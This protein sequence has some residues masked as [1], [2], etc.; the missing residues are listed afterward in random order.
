MFIGQYH[1]RL[2]GKGRLSV[3]R[4]FRKKIGE[5]AVITRGLDGCLFLFPHDKWQELAEKLKETPLTS[6]DARAFSRLLTYGGFEVSIDKQG[7][8]LIPEILRKFAKLKE[9]VMVAGSLDRIEIWDQETFEAYQQKIEKTSDDIA[10]RISK[11]EIR[12]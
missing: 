2:E 10:E 4:E 11:L 6:L 12:I 1:H 9:K 5:K 8:I 3:P 7:R